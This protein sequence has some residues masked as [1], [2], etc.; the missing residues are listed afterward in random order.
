VYAQQVWAIVGYVFAANYSE[1]V[2]PMMAIK[3]LLDKKSRFLFTVVGLGTLFFLSAAQIGL[4]VAWCNTNSA[5]IRHAGVDVWVMAGQTPAFDYGTAIPKNRIYQSRSIEGVARAEG[6]FMAWNVWQR[7]DGRRV[8]VEVVGLDRGSVG[9]PWSLL[10]GQVDDVQRPD[11]VLVDELY[12]PLLGIEKVGDEAELIGHRAV[13]RGISREVRTFTA[14]PFVFTSI[15]SAIQYD[16]RY[17]SDEITY[18]LVRCAPGYQPARVAASLREA[19][20]H[21]EVLTTDQF[22][23]R[24]VRYWMLE[25]G[26]GITVVLTAILGAVVSVVVSSQTLFTVTQEHLSNYGTL[27]ALGFSRVSLLGCV[28]AQSLLLGGL[29]IVLGTAGFFVAA[30][31]SARTPIPLETTVPV[32]SGLMVLS[33][34]SSVGSSYL[35]LRA[36]FS[37]DPVIVFRG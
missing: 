18:V 32:F 3:M 29:G 14:S 16:K 33:L 2:G 31:L 21:V 8:N 24:T 6:M 19:L 10:E 35:S 13:V 20:P 26:I 37:V 11:S 30:A 36:V 4:L 27:V 12:L 9:G 22:V 17:R 28:V 25:T 1:Q 15:R 23:V 5:I 34:T 7:R